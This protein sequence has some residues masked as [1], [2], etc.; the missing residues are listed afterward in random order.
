MKRSTHICGIVLLG[1]P[2]A[3]LSIGMVAIL[4]SFDCIHTQQWVQSPTVRRFS[5]GNVG[6][7]KSVAG[8]C[9]RMGVQNN[10]TWEFHHIA[11]TCMLENIKICV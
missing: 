6:S 5:F 10:T 3:A 7:V 2:M 11:A 1:M 9:H 4:N 8:R